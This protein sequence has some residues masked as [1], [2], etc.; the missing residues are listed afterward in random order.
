MKSRE[1]LAEALEVKTYIQS[2]ILLQRNIKL[3]F[4]EK[5]CKKEAIVGARSE[6]ECSFRLLR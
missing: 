4:Q 6:I 1:R 2:I 5:K 3:I